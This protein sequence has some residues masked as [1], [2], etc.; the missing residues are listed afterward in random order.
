MAITI[1]AGQEAKITL[2]MLADGAP[3]PIALDAQVRVQLRSADGTSALFDPVLVTSDAPGANWAKGIVAVTIN[4]DMT[5]TLPQPAV[6]LAIAGPGFIKRFQLN[7]ES[8]TA[9]TRSALFIKDFAIDE[10]RGDRLALMAQTFFPSVRLTDDFLW[11]KLLTAE[12]QIAGDAGLRVPLVPT[13]FFPDTP[14]DTEISALNGLPWA[15]D[16]GY[17]YEP[18]FFRADRFAFIVTRQKPIVDVLRVRFVY[19]TGVESSYEFPRPWIQFDRKYGHIRIVPTSATINAPIGAYALQA[20]G[21]GRAIPFAIK[22][23][24]IAGLEDARKTYPQLV[25]VIKRMAVLKVIEDGFVAAS[26][27]IS[28]DGLSQSMSVDMQRYRDTIEMVLN[29]PKGSNGGLMAAIHGIR[30]MSMS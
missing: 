14:T 29:G 13:R 3:I 20:L 21:A 23:D 2:T 6:L 11:E 7:V 15:I 4:A 25:D 26:G 28:A 12:A 16:P 5:A 17:E 18:D 27:S 24:Y 30:M 22:V 19:P 10:L 9:P 8:S 1:V